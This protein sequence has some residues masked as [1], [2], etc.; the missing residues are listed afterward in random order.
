MLS[1][2][3]FGNLKHSEAFLTYYIYNTTFL[4]LLSGC[5]FVYLQNLINEL[6]PHQCDCGIHT[7]CELDAFFPATGIFRSARRFR[8][9]NGAKTSHATTNRIV[10]AVDNTRNTAESIVVDNAM[11]ALTLTATISDIVQR[12]TNGEYQCPP[13][14]T[15]FPSLY[16]LE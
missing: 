10:R 9:V 11:S 16:I 1:A 13:A 3:R 5:P 14:N 6:A 7:V 15:E 2:K 12:Y 4:I 8:S